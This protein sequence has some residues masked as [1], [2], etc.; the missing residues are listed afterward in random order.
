M[1]C[2]MMVALIIKDVDL[3]L[4]DRPAVALGFPCC[5]IPDRTGVEAREEPAGDIRNRWAL[6]CLQGTPPPMIVLVQ[7]PRRATPT[8]HMRHDRD[9]AKPGRH[10]AA[11]KR[12]GRDPGE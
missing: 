7:R 12:G 11:G 6:S 2:N 5:P 10:R 4:G 9:A 1:P 3:V 8:G